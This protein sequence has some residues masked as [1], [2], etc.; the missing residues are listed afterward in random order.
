MFQILVF[1]ILT[2]ISSIQ[3]AR[4]GNFEGMK[5]MPLAVPSKTYTVPSKEAGE[6]LVEARGFGD[7]EPSVRMMN[8]MMVEGSGF[9]GMDMAEGMASKKT[10]VAPHSHSGSLA[11]TLAKSTIEI[12]KAP[13]PAKVGSN[14]FEFRMKPENAER[15]S[16]KQSPVLQVSMTTM[17]M[18]TDRPEMVQISPGTYRAKVLFSMEGPWELKITTKQES[19][20]FVVDVVRK[21]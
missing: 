5:E 19:K 12:T 7:Q 16:S 15:A 13:A 2:A 10:P 8:L 6:S 21:K 17:D 20:S 3:S 4:A 9:E 18:G 14:V 1:A 11:K